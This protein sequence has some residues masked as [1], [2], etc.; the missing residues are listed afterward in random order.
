MAVVQPVR[1]MPG[2]A[3]P[4]PPAAAVNSHTPQSGNRS[5]SVSAH[6]LREDHRTLSRSLAH[7]INFNSRNLAFPLHVVQVL[8]LLADVR[9][10]GA[11]LLQLFRHRRSRGRFLGPQFSQRLLPRHAHKT[12][13]GKRCRVSSSSLYASRRQRKRWLT[14]ILWY[15]V[16][17]SSSVPCNAAMLLRSALSCPASSL[18]SARRAS[19]TALIRSS[20]RTPSLRAL[21]SCTRATAFGRCERTKW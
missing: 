7:L 10:E 1:P 15:F 19:V 13:T 20:S 18:C 9:F 3:R 11:C 14:E 12:S 21:E 5:S 8:A 4:W 17:H 6:T 2:H 16:L